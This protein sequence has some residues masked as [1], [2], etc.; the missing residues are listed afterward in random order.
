MATL[1]N[2]IM[3]RQRVQDPLRESVCER[4]RRG[5]M[6]FD[7]VVLAD[8]RS[9]RLRRMRRGDRAMYRQAVAE[10]S[11]RSRHLRFA[12]PMPK[13][14]ESLLDQMMALDA[15]R[16]V[17]YAALTPDGTAIVGVA[18]FARAAH[19]PNTAEV[20]I[21]IADDWQG[22]GLGSAL[23]T[24]IVGRA[25]DAGLSRLTAHTLSENRPAACLA[26]AVGFS[27]AA[28]AGICSEYKLTLGNACE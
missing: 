16:H 20:A 26:R 10:L 22:R 25:R 8:G 4:D 18:R 24:R 27:L 9:V 6:T 2:E 17:A 23:L 13:M 28:R 21:A 14:S 12:A 1:L 11:P 19:D 3:A 15:D 7:Q 5:A